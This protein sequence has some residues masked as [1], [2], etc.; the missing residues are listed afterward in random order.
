V[1][2]PNSNS[3]EKGIIYDAKH[4]RNWDSSACITPDGL[5]KVTGYWHFKFI[6]KTLTFT[7]L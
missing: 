2:I 5:L 7:R 3:W 6:G 4:G 1:Y